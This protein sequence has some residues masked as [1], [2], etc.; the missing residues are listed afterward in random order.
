V[1]ALFRLL[2][3]CI[4]IF[5]MA[6]FLFVAIS[7]IGDS[8]M[9]SFPPH[10]FTLQ[11]YERMSPKLVDALKTSLLAATA[12]MAI[13]SSLGLWMALAIARG[14]GAF[15]NFL[16]AASIAPLSVPHLAI[17]IALYQA[18]LLL[19][20]Y[21]GVTLA[22]TFPGLVLGHSAIALPFVIR[23]VLA[24]HSHLDPA[25][26]EAA[27]SLGATPLR[28]LWTMTFP[29]IRPGLV[30]GAFFAFLA[31][32]DDVPIALFMGGG[33]DSTTFP[34][35]VLA[36]LEFSLKPDIMA[37]STLI[38]VASVSVLIALEYLFGLERFLHD[39]SA[40]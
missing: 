27:L 18:V 14:R 21:S 8:A 38:V 26:E 35:Q 24:G 37:I 4:Y 12:T 40:N 28:A 1:R 5:L 23:G 6:P 3:V 34:L 19:W 31:S 15:V 25:I 39:Q 7:S 2:I 20:D 22:G 16:K 9:L 17:G 10:S 36:S 11:W 33:E 30:S 29:L 13:A 32:F